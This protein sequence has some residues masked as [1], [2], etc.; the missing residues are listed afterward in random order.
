MSVEGRNWAGSTPGSNWSQWHR[1]LLNSARAGF[2]RGWKAPAPAGRRRDVNTDAPREPSPANA[3]P[4]SA[5]STARGKEA[6]ENLWEEQLF[7]LQFNHV[8]QSKKYRHVNWHKKEVYFQPFHLFFF[9]KL[10]HSHSER[11]SEL[12]LFL[13]SFINSISSSENARLRLLF[14]YIHILYL[15]HKL[16][17]HPP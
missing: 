16:F 15:W 5:I 13:K 11:K 7:F 17:C 3:G 14:F 2:E 10:P 4:D 12:R 6:A 9:F 1:V 8:T